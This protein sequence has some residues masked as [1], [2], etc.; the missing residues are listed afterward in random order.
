MAVVNSVICSYFFNIDT[1]FITLRFLFP[2]S[3]SFVI[4][5]IPD[6]YRGSKSTT[7]I[8]ITTGTNNNYRQ[9]QTFVWFSRIYRTFFKKI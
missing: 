1:D 9:V 6:Y 2:F 8:S 3:L 7:G 5:I 4:C